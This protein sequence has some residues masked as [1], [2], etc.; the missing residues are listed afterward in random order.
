[1]P[2]NAFLLRLGTT[3]DWS[4][5]CSMVRARQEPGSFRNQALTLPPE[6]RMR[7]EGRRTNA[8]L[9]PRHSLEPVRGFVVYL[10]DAI[11]RRDPIR[12]G[13]LIHEQAAL[14]GVSFI[15]RREFDCFAE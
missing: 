13:L 9:S 14:V 2:G 1:M 12:L 15:R 11:D 5:A 8:R 3:Q 4:L 7:L 6:I 10:C